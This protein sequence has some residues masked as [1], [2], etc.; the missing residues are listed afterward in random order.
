M[1]LVAVIAAKSGKVRKVALQ[2]ASNVLQVEP[3]DVV[4]VV[5]EATGKRVE[6][7]Q[8]TQEGGQVTINLPQAPEGASPGADGLSP[9]AGAE[10]VQPAAAASGGLGGTAGL[11]LLGVLTAAGAGLAAAG[12]GGGG[13]GSKAAPDVTP[14][15]APTGLALDAADDTGRS[16]TDGRTSRD[17]GLTITGQAEAGST[18]TLSRGSTTLGSGQADASGRFSIDISLAEGSHEVT[19]VAK[20]AAGNASSPSAVLALI[21][22]KTAPAAPGGLSLAAE[23]DTGLSSSDGVTSRTS[24]LTVSGVAEAGALVTVRDGATVLGTPTADASTGRFSLDVALSAGDHALS[25]TAMDAAGNVS[26]ASAALDLRIDTAAPSLVITSDRAV[27]LGGQTAQLTFTFSEAPVGFTGSDIVTSGGVVSGVAVSA[28]DPNVYTAILTPAGGAAGAISVSV[29]AGSLSDRAGNLLASA[30]SA[31]LTFDPGTGGQAIDGY[32]ANALVF[33]DGSNGF[34]A[35]GIWNHEAFTDANNNGL[36]DAG[37]AFVDANGDGVFNAEYAT[38]TDNNGDFSGLFGSGRIVVAPLIAG[39]GTN[40]TRDISTGLAFTARYTAPDGATVVTPLTSIVEALVSSGQSKAQAEAQVKTALGLDPSVSLGSFDPLAAAR[41]P[42]QAAI[43][44]EVQKAAIQVANVLSI[45]ASASEAAG[46]SDGGKSATGAAVGAIAAQVAGGGALDLSR[47]QTIQAVVQT[48]AAQAPQAEAAQLTGQAANLASS[49]ANVNAAV[50]QASGE[51]VTDTFAAIVTAQIV[52]QDRLGGDV[53][54]AVRTGGALDTAQYSGTALT[55]KIDAA[56]S[57]VQSVLPVQNPV[58]PLGAPER[59]LIDP[60]V[61]ARISQAEALAGVGVSVSYGADRGVAAG[62]AIRLYVG[63][64]LVATR[65]LGAGDIPAAGGSSSQAFLL[66]QADLGADGAKSLSAEFVSAAGGAGARSLPLIVN[67]DTST[68]S[69][70][71]NP[72]SGGFINATEAL[73]GVDIVLG[74]ME[75]GSTA[76]IEITGGAPGQV[77][78]RTLGGTGSTFTLDAA[79]L[80][81]FADGTLNISVVQTDVSGNVSAAGLGSVILDRAV[82]AP[83]NLALDPAD[84]TGGSNSDR[85]TSRTEGLTV[86]GRAE[87]NATVA[88]LEGAVVRGTGLADADGRFSIDVALSAGDHVLVGRA[89]DPAGNVSGVSAGLAITVDPQAPAQP[90]QLRL[91]PSSDTGRSSSDGITAATSLPVTGQAEAGSTVTLRSGATVVGTGSADAQGRF[92]ITASLAEGPHALSATATDAAGLVS[93]ASSP[94]A[95]IVDRTA[96]QAAPVFQLAAEDDTGASSSDGVTS[97]SSGLTLLGA[98]EAGSTVQFFDGATPLGSVQ[99]GP[100]GGFA[101][102]VSLATG[103]HSITAVATDA[104]GN[105]GP[106]SQTQSIVVD[107]TAPAAPSQ[108]AVDDG[109]L[110]SFLEAA[111]GIRITGLAESGVAVRVTITRNATTL[112][113]DVTAGPAGFAV[114]L[115]AADLAALGEGTI[116]YSAVATDAAGNSSDVSAT[117]QFLYSTQARTDSTQP[118]DDFVSLHLLNERANVQISP[119]AGGGFVAH[120]VVDTNFDD[121]PETI[122]LQRFGADGAKVG[123]VSLLQGVASQLLTAGDNVGAVDFRALEGGGLALAYTL[124]NPSQVWSLTRTASAAGVADFEFSGVATQVRV[125]G[126][127]AGA[128]Y[129]YV[130]LSKAGEALRVTLTP[131]AQ[132]NLPVTREF[133]DQ[134]AQPDRLYLLVKN[135]A[136]GASVSLTY[137]AA[138]TTF[139]DPTS[140]TREVAARYDVSATPGISGPASESGLISF[141]SGRV[142]G[143]HIQSATYAPTGPQIYLLRIATARDPATYNLAGIPNAT[144]GADGT[145]NITVAPDANNDIR[146][147]ASLLAQLGSEDA[148]VFAYSL[149]MAPGASFSATAIVRDGTSYPTGVFVQ[150]F[151]AAGVAT[152]NGLTRVDD[153][154]APRA[155]EEAAFTGLVNGPDGGFG[156]YWTV[157]RDLDG[158]PDTIALRDVGAN[159]AAQGAPVLLQNLS[160]VLLND[161]SNITGFDIARL[162][163]GRTVV[164]YSA[165]GETSSYQATSFGQVSGPTVLPI[166]GRPSEIQVVSAPA[167][168]TFSLTFRNAAGVQT[169]LPVLLVDGRLDITPAIRVQLPSDSQ[170]SLVTTGL[171][172]GGAGSQ[173]VF[174]IEVVQTY[175]VDPANPL[176]VETVAQPPGS[177]ALGASSSSRSEAFHLDASAGT[178]TQALLFVRPAGGPAGISL[179][180]LSGAIANADGSFLIPLPVSASGDYVVPP[181]ILSQLGNQSAAMA[182]IFLG[183]PQGSTISGTVTGRPLT[184]YPEGV[185]VQTFDANGAAVGPASARL[186]TGPNAVTSHDDAQVGLTTLPGGGYGLYWSRDADLNGQTDGIAVQRFNADGTIHGA[187]VVLQGLQERIAALGDNIQ[188]YDLEALANGGYALTY[189]VDPTQFSKV[190][191]VTAPASGG[192]FSMAYVGAPAELRI[193][194]A[195][196]NAVYSLVGVGLDGQVTAVQLTP[197]ADGTIQVSASL[198]SQFDAPGRT[199]IAVANATPSATVT[200]SVDV[201]QVVSVDLAAPLQSQAV[202]QFDVGGQGVSG[203]GSVMRGLAGSEGRIE[204]FHIDAATYAATGPRLY[205]LVIV[206]AR[207]ARSYDLSG[208]TGASVGAGGSIYLTVQPDANN[209]VRV[210]QSLLN[211]LGSEDAVVIAVA[212]NLAAGA[213]FAATALVRPTVDV[214]LGVFVQTFDAAG[215]PIGPDLAFTGTAGADRI[216]GGDGADILTSGGGLDVLLAGAGDDV[217]VLSGP[218][219]AGSVFDGG[220][221]VDA[222]RLTPAAASLTLPNGAPAVALS[223]ASLTG[224]ETLVFDSVAGGSLGAVVRLDQLAAGITFVGGAGADQVVIQA[225]AGGGVFTMPSYS[226]SNW[227]AGDIVRIE[228]TDA[229]SAYTLNAG[230]HPGVLVLRGNA[231]A[232]TLVGGSGTDALVGAGGPD[233]LT[234]NGGADIFALD[235]SAGRTLSGADLITDFQPGLDKMLLPAGLTFGDVQAVRG[236]SGSYGGLASE[237]LVVVSATGDILAR[238]A[239]TDAAAVTAASFL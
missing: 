32:V 147:P 182:M 124:D 145:I 168:A 142:E 20:D 217:L 98:A 44:V 222:L 96:P 107:A 122:A 6:Q 195:G 153:V 233:V 141:A 79:T 162:A 196:P 11:G 80:A 207:D 226:L 209:D 38:V 215:L 109:P 235:A 41:D 37:E 163:D 16:A 123:G 219:A 40:L 185:F 190:I 61:G 212:L 106:V 76:A 26:A 91:D 22:D 10:T 231:G 224:I 103:T 90:S 161:N 239:N 167:N 165:A 8:V 70:V 221:G 234:G 92:S 126:A 78:T 121:Q 73:A 55:D 68:V 223:G 178:P 28:N 95:V 111:D 67:L 158:Q 12:G 87:A 1:A 24:G 228:A 135:V 48:V 77:V 54:S 188:S 60:A 177:I 42:A 134:F 58:G 199:N 21:V 146:V 150:T 191:S 89:T 65:V 133:L 187:P 27:V 5:D 29:A 184:A 151:D 175:Y 230:D 99:A 189:S 112:V 81:S 25:A 137:N 193:T 131:D 34:A 197:A 204:G 236:D 84:D 218:V 15:G 172:S 116:R 2:K 211:Q 75:T 36:R 213:N 194:G 220:Q 46:A 97:R 119:L 238:L 49:L 164:A 101:L 52:A 181:Q 31:S 138:Q 169:S 203:A 200:L 120:W 192:P 45:V 208:T 57:Q 94:L 118:L 113:R 50:A 176:R 7:A 155:A 179:A 227:L 86:T 117:G 206:T 4:S 62:D 166:L 56:A 17:S 180:G 93:Q 210:P 130:G 88:I 154:T 110:V 66:S 201:L 171:T 74:R 33:R 129:E 139:Y 9:G 114:Q 72:V 170:V 100:N 148:W 35:D 14:P 136:A 186:D 64:V 47:P 132:G 102:D 108:V 216:L 18:V 149:N 160:P 39:N 30:A 105:A 157:D 13:G 85:I 232:D 174:R 3:G 144:V 152:S 198:L 229:S 205:Q 173:A 202:S 183:L 104:A 63:D 214:P 23:D 51:T 140:A 125:Q 159:G 128:T 143:F 237:S 225:P 69:P 71:V 115:T 19:A 156:V 59:P 82:A 53:A 83:V 43:A 127:S